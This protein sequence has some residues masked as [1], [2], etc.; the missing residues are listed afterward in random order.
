MSERPEEWGAMFWDIGGVILA[1][2]SVGRAHEA[3]VDSLVAELELSVEPEQAIETWRGAVGRYFRERE[4]TEFRSAEEAYRRG[5]D[6]VAG[7]S[8]AQSTWYSVL[9]SAFL[10]HVEPEPDAISTVQE[11]ASREIHLGIVSDI[12]QREADMI[13][14]EFGLTSAFDSVT[15]SEEV[16]RTKPDQQ[17]FETALAKASVSPDRALMIGDRYSHDMQGGA[18]AGMWTIAYGADDGPAV[19]FRVTELPDVLEI[20]DGTRGV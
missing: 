5:V 16:G 20:V 11:T 14:A 1:H 4:G 2:D 7:E 9:E 3:F 6:A 18:D 8:V 10:E 13:L 17:M 15:T 12:D 19:D